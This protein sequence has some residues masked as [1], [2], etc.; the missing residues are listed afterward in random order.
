MADI[1]DEGGRRA[2][3]QLQRARLARLIEMIDVDPVHRGGLALGLG[4]EVALHEGE[5]AGTR[6][7]HHVHVVA[8]ARHRH[9]EL[10]RLHRALLAEHAAKRLEV[11]SGGEVELVGSAGTG[12]G[13]GRQAQA[14]SE[15]FGHRK[16][17][18]ERA[19]RKMGP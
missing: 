11:V 12:Q 18:S 3:R 17:L 9:A 2:W 1:G 8:G 13:I 16:S 10:Q 5:A 14:G 15:G 7:A 4:L 19:S 6:L